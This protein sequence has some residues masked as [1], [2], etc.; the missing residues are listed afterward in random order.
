[1]SNFKIQGPLCFP[2]PAPVVRQ[3][4]HLNH[5][6]ICG[7]LVIVPKL[8][9]CCFRSVASIHARHAVHALASVNK[10]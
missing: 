5:T 4:V 3:S 1:M 2:L 8:R 7:E 9:V 10:T 6:P